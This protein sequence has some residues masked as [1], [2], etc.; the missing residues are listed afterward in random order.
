MNVHLFL[1]FITTMRSLIFLKKL[2]VLDSV[3]NDCLCLIAGFLAK[4][5]M[6]YL[7]QIWVRHAVSSGF[8]QQV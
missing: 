4:G 8:I 3:L 1:Y 2:I 6:S 5:K 7:G